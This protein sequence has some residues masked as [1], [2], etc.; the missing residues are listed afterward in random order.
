VAAEN[1]RFG[2]PAVLRDVL[3]NGVSSPI[4]SIVI[5]TH[6]RADMLGGAIESA[7][8]QSGSAG[9]LE[10]IVVDDASTDQTPDVIERYGRAVVGLRNEH[11]RERG[12]SRNIGAANARGRWLA[13]LDSDD[14]WEDDKLAVQLEAVGPAKACLTECWLI[15]E[16]GL[17]LGRGHVTTP[18]RG[19]DVDL[20]NPYRAVPSSL[21]VDRDLFMSIGGF[22]EQ[23]ELQG[24]EDWL[25]MAKLLRA[26]SD[27]AWVDQPLVRYRVHDRNSTASPD[28]YLRSCLAAIDWLERQELASA[29]RARLAR[30]EKYDVAARAHA[31]RGEVSSA[32]RLARLAVA[33]T[34]IGGRLGLLREMAGAGLIAVS[35]RAVPGWFG[36]DR[37]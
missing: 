26:N 18:P 14:E 4:V 27:P 30:A 9:S 35:R 5:P 13:F 29:E 24:S 25:L 2:W 19:A 31:L 22:P 8:R 36:A 7:L 37:V 23:R 6:N 34:P 16:A 1:D 33:Q 21:L 15:D 20:I 17:P 12:A 11:N 28:Q 3:A 32:L 10:V